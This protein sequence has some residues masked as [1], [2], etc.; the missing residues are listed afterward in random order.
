MFGRQNIQGLSQAGIDDND[1]FFAHKE[2]CLASGNQLMEDVDAEIFNNPL[3]ESIK[4]LFLVGI[5]LSCSQR[6]SSSCLWHLFLPGKMASI[7][8][9]LQIKQKN[10]SKIN[11]YLT[12]H[13][14][15]SRS[16]I[17]RP[18][19]GQILRQEI[20]NGMAVPSRYFA[21]MLFSSRC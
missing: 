17:I 15:Q 2:G 3:A 6:Y 16:K 9:S 20:K 4:K 21:A 12:P 7:K 5:E 10:L 14:S 8:K 11:I 1:P 19:L 13:F 18:K